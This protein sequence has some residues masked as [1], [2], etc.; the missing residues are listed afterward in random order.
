MLSFI[1]RR[2]VISVIT[3]LA[4]VTITFFMVRAMPGNP[5]ASEKNV[6]EEIRMTQMAKY[7]FDKPILEQYRLFMKNLFLGDLGLSLKYKDWTVNEIIA[8]SLPVSAFLG[9]IALVFAVFIG[10]VAGAFAAAKRNSI[11]DYS[12]MA[13]VVLG[14]CIPNFVIAPVLILLFSFQIKLFPPGGWGTVSTLVLPA[15]TLSLPYIAYI[16]RLTRAGMLEALN[17]DYIRTA[18]AK[19][20]PSSKV[21]FEHALRNSII[22]VVTFLGPAA[23]GILTGSF[24]VEYIFNIPGLGIHFVNAV[25]NKDYFLISGIVVVDSA[26]LIFFN[27][28]VDISYA[29]I[30]PRVKVE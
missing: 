14:V 7:G 10:V 8:M 3:L 4:V 20:L 16:S 6:P 15:F 30:D 22:P 12:T 13:G 19:G 25:Q 23:A 29:Y 5:F 11:I 24:V 21:T 17:K 18:R 27:L 1:T 2:L 28:L 9:F 26:L